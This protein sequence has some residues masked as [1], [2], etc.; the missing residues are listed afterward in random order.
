MGFKEWIIPQD[1]VFYDLL[2]RHVALASDAAG[3]FRQ[4]VDNWQNVEAWRTRIR[5]VEHEADSVGHE[6]FDRLNATFITPIDREDIAR[7]AHALD[8]I[9]D[10]IY[11]ATNRIALL[12]IPAPTPHMK[13]FIDVLEGQIRELVDGVRGL[14]KP[15]SLKTTIPAHVVEIHRLENVADRALNEAI[16]ALFKTNDP[17]VILKYKEIYEFLEDATDR[18]EDV[19]DVLQD[20]LRKH[21]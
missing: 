5:D 6:V 15:S 16:G 7:L 20:I 9:V 19:A 21:G 11:A 1:R 4:M 3:L 10:A 14:R 2:E 17:V 12:E 13:V 18:C 8:D